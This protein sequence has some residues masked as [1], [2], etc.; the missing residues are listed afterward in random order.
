MFLSSPF[1]LLL[2]DHILL[3]S[4]V[5]PPPHTKGKANSQGNDELPPSERSPPNPPNGTLQTLRI[6][7]PTTRL[8]TFITG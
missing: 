7:N 1:L 2:F 6:Y 3:L 8:P 5:D 4:I